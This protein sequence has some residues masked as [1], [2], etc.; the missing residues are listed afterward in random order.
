M[1]PKKIRCGAKDGGVQCREGVSRIVG[2]CGFC[3]GCFC[4]KHRLL[5]DHKCA[6]L[7]DVSA[8]PAFASF[9]AGNTPNQEKKEEELFPAITP[10]KEKG[11]METEKQ[12]ETKEEENMRRKTS[13]ELSVG[14]LGVVIDHDWS[15]E[16]VARLAGGK[17]DWWLAGLDLRSLGVLDS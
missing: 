2:E 3:G 12:K 5:E 15:V 11:E 13:S 16:T 6:G 9:S 8:H 14:E 10:V 4:G 1:P 7:E 17:L